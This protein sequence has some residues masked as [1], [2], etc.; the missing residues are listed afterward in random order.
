M[1][2]TFLNKIPF[3]LPFGKAEDTPSPALS[4]A[5]SRRLRLRPW[6][7]GSGT[8]STFAQFGFYF[9]QNWT[10]F[11]YRTK[12]SV[13]KINE[14]WNFEWQMVSG[15]LWLVNCD[16]W[17]VIGELWVVNC[18]WWIVIGELWVVKKILSGLFSYN[19][20]GIQKFFLIVSQRFI[21]LYI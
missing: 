7:L 9:V 13:K 14:L 1:R 6:C 2:Y 12:L 20:P 11:I 4:K 8:S 19:K 5:R 21:G 3:C 18:E 17:I 16:W 15:E 10:I